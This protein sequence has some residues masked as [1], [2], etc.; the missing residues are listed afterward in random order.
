MFSG[1]GDRQ[2]LNLSNS[3]DFSASEDGKVERMR[4]VVEKQRNESE[5]F[6]QSTPLHI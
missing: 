4:I 3:Y 6:D 1:V 2:L 5:E